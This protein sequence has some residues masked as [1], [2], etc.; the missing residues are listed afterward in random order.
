MIKKRLNIQIIIFLVI[1]LNSFNIYSQNCSN[2]VISAGSDTSICINEAIQLG[3]NPTASWI[4]TGNPNVTYTYQWSA[5]VSNDTISNPIVSPTVTTVYQ[6]I[7][8][9]VPF[10]TTSCTDTVSITITV[11]QLPVLNLSTFND[12]CEGD[13]S[14]LLTGESPLGGDYSGNGV[15][16]NIATK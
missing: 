8:T 16:N 13:N 15:N 10:L 2:L 11:L 4:N 12:V 3:G 6:L 9:A 1:L 5:G 14:F 7:V